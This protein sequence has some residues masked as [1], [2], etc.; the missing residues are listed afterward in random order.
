MNGLD[1]LS[2]LLS[3]ATSAP[4]DFTRAVVAAVFLRAPADAEWWSK[5]F[6]ADEYERL[7]TKFREGMPQTLS[8]LLEMKA[9]AERKLYR[10]GS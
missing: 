3:E 4:L 1:L 2:Q 9:R 10:G 5:E 6:S 8:W 7:L